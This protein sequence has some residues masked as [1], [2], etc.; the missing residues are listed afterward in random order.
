MN[1][2]N[3]AVDVTAN[4][5]RITIC[6]CIQCCGPSSTDQMYSEFNSYGLS[7]GFVSLS[8]FEP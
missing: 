5:F 1:D 8:I 7:F 2:L 4:K 6:I 3:A